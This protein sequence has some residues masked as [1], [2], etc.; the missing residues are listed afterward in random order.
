MPRTVA[1]WQGG[2]A[3]TLF[4]S[5]LLK[6]LLLVEMD[7]QLLRTPSL[8]EVSGRPFGFSFLK[9]LISSF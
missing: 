7:G 9:T 1:A 5:L 2:Q 3:L 6:K 8:G 4:R